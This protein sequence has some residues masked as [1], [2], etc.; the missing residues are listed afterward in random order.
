[1]WR[2][3]CY[4][5]IAV[6]HNADFRF[7]VR[8][9]VTQ[10]GFCIPGYRLVCSGLSATR[11]SD[12]V[13][14][15]IADAGVLPAHRVMQR[16]NACIAPMPVEIERRMRRACARQFE[17]FVAGLDGDFGCQRLGLGDRD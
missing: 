8:D 13:E 17:Q 4:S 14:I 2:Y 9:D 12:A 16:M 7:A 15:E 3:A 10:P 5:A 1:M 6:R 11:R